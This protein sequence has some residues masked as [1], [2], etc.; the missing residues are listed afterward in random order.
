MPDFK[1]A[2]YTF[3][4][5]SHCNRYIGS[6]FFTDTMVSENLVSVR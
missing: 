4:I 3:C 5:L 6:L 2:N 1:Q